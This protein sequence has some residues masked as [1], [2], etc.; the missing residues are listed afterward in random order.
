[1]SRIKHVVSLLIILGFWQALACADGPATQPQPRDAAPAAMPATRPEPNPDLSPA[2]VVRIQMEAMQHND[3]PEKDAG[4]A[5]VFRFASPRNREQTGP[6]P[7]FTDVV[8]SP[9]YAPMLGYR[10]AEYSKVEMEDGIAQ[11]L[12]RIV[13]SGGNTVLYLFKLSRQTDGEY[14][15][16]W[17]NESAIFV[18]FIPARPP[19]PIHDPVQEKT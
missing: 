6:L 12:V 1:M 11:V 9:Q 2:D 8:K 14:K 15:D 18:S 4:I 16:C 5:T 3:I 13:D 19:P 7:H 17:M 10:S